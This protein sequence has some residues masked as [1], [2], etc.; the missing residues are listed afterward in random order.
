MHTARSKPRRTVGPKNYPRR[1]SVAPGGSRRRFPRIDYGGICVFEILDV[2][3]DKDEI[4]DDR[5]R[6]DQPVNITAGTD[7]RDAAPFDRDLVCY[8]QNAVAMV[9][10]QLAQPF[11]EVRCRLWIRPLF[12]G[13]AAHDLAEGERAQVD[14]ERIDRAQPV[15]R[16]RRATSRL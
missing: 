2:A 6:G 1:V 13:N 11:G 7:C 16:L 9:V 3:S 8:R 10:A 12:Q 14:A 4:V 15:H 5:G